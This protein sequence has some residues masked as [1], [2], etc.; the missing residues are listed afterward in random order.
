MLTLF[1]PGIEFL[2]DHLKK[3]L[4]HVL[5]TLIAGKKKDSKQLTIFSSGEGD[6]NVFVSYIIA[7]P[8]WKT[9]YRMLLPKHDDEKSLTKATLQGWALVD[10]TSDEDWNNVNLTLVSGLPISFTHDLYSPRYK[11]RPEIKVEEEEAYAPPVLEAAT[12]DS[13]YIDR[14]ERRSRDS[15]SHFNHDYNRSVGLG[16]GRGRGGGGNRSLTDLYNESQGIRS[17]STAR[18]EIR[19]AQAEQVQVKTA[20]IGDLFSYE[21]S[22]AVTV[23]R[24]G[25][26]LVPIY[27]G[28]TETKKIA[29]YNSSIHN[30]NPMSAILLKNTTNV[31]LEGGPVTVLENENYVGEAMLDTIKSNE[32]K[33]LPYSVELSCKISSN[34]VTGNHRSQVH[35]VKIENGYMYQY[36][37]TLYEVK[38]TIDNSV[39]ER[40]IELYLEHSFQRG[41]ELIDTKPL[42]IETT[43]NYYRFNLGT[44]EKKSKRQFVV[45][46]R[47]L[48][49]SSFSLATVTL[50][51]VNNWLISGYIT[52]DLAKTLNGLVTLVQTV[53][54]NQTELNKCNTEINNQT[55]NQ[56]RVRQNLSSLNKKD[57]AKARIRFIEELET[58]ENIITTLQQERIKLQQ[59][60]EQA[61]EKMNSYIRDIHFSKQIPDS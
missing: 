2:D 24:N 57:D 14:S 6:R 48:N 19:E 21:I 56:N 29:I 3:D 55:S 38:Y 46:E 40:S 7:S 12:K 53:K 28:S 39:N 9:S 18:A 54:S 35:E 51:Q 36:H 49:H 31:T 30:K 27:Q 26:G 42:P 37:Y 16:R 32:E 41:F 34:M 25:A 8:V 45:V 33:I 13:R 52:D 43:E 4:Q 58:S 1:L 17:S 61:N 44:I 10:N 23:R 11:T 50:Q 15:D 20:E 47:Q 22:H 60:L 59:A 5:Q